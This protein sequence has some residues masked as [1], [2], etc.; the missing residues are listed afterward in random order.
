MLR[1]ETLLFGGKNKESG[2]TAD[3]ISSAYRQWLDKLTHAVR[4]CSA[5]GTSYIKVTS[6]S[7]VGL[8]SCVFVR[9]DQKDQLRDIDITTVKR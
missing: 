4:L 3:K 1:T 5:P 2:S 6:D 8:F 9:S 7:L